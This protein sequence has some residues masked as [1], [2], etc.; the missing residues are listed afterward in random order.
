M[1]WKVWMVRRISTPVVGLASDS[2]VAASARRARDWRA[3]WSDRRGGRCLGVGGQGEG[4][5]GECG[6]EEA[7]GL[8]E[9]QFHGH[10]LV[11]LVQNLD[12]PC[13]EGTLGHGGSRDKIGSAEGGEEA[14]VSGGLAG[15]VDDEPVA[16]ELAF[17]ADPGGEPP[18]D[19]VEEEE[20]FDEALQDE[21]QVVVT[22]EVGEFVQEGH[23]ELVDGPAA[24]RGGG[25]EDQGA[26]DADE[27]G[28]GEV[29]ADGDADAAG[30]AEGV[31]QGA[32]AVG[33]GAGV[34][35]EAGVAEF[36]DTDEAGGEEG[37]GEKRAGEP[38]GGE[39]G[40]EGGES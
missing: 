37:E 32:A 3:V 22:A 29:V 9:C 18:G 19:G 24:Q 23:F 40:D 2:W 7:E 4:E 27:D 21:D 20:G 14:G 39:V 11:I 10:C 26:Q 31:G 28:G 6:G 35:R 30:D 12:D 36:F 8:G 15:A 1:L 5:A 38:D 33:D 17:E 25:D 34:E 16:A 13:H